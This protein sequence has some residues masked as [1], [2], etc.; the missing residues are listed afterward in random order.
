VHEQGGMGVVYRVRHL[1]WGIDL[2][3]KSPRPDLFR[4]PDD[5]R[6]FVAEAETWVSLGLHRFWRCVPAR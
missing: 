4:S 1:A 6:R 2:A 3:V 5:R